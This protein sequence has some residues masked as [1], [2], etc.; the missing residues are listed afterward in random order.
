LRSDKLPG[1]GRDVYR[2][3]R[4]WY[5]FVTAPDA[6]VGE[7]P[8]EGTKGLQMSHGSSSRI[9][10]AVPT[11]LI[12]IGILTGCAVRQPVSRDSETGLVLAYR[13]PDDQTLRY[14]V[15]IEQ[16]HRMESPV[17][18]RGFEF[19]KTLEFSIQSTGSAE[20]NH[21][22]TITVD[23]LIVELDTPRGEIKR[24]IHE[25]L[26]KSFGMTLSPLGREVNF[27]GTGEVRYEQP[28]AGTL[29]VRTDLEG[30]FPNLKDGPVRVGESWKSSDLLTDTAFNSEK[31]IHLQSVH[32][33]TGFETLDGME[34]AK[35]STRMNGM[36]EQVGDRMTRAPE[37]TA[38]FEGMATWH[39]ALEEGLL[40]R[41]STTLRGGGEMITGGGKGP[42]TR[43]SQEMTTDI[44]LL[45]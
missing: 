8:P 21:D 14:R 23:S 30:F 5:Y 16:T 10:F 24:V 33:L 2:C 3:G 45:P 13:T 29:N 31:K 40:V 18:S 39:F 41:M 19:D 32:T 25:V 42:P 26:G 37:M 22:L 28:P 12:A 38:R 17:E 6:R 7:G 34:C 44:R 35:F 20:G 9:C 36:L 1:A 4:N 27:S 15:T 11:L 43:M